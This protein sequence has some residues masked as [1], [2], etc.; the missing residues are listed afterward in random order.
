MKVPVR[1]DMACRRAEGQV[2]RSRTAR[3]G[4]IAETVGTVGEW[5]DKLGTEDGLL[6]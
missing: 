2:R 3:Q 5:L 6:R 4:I 1:L